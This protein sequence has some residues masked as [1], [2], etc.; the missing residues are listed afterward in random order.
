MTSILDIRL[1][2]AELSGFKLE[3]TVKLMKL[4]LSRLLSQYPELDITVDQWVIMY[5]LDKNE[6]L[7]QQEIAESAFKDAPTVTRMLD[8]MEAKNLV[9]RLQDNLDKRRFMIQLTL[10]G[11]EKLALMEPIVKAFR[12]DAYEGLTDDQLVFLDNTLNIIFNN[13]SKIN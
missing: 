10:V 8:L 9:S 4:T 3:K 2:K 6:Y 13:L 11:K 5:L 12:E 7:S 1:H